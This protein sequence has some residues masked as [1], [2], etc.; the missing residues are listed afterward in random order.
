MYSVFM[1]CF[2]IFLYIF[3]QKYVFYVD[4]KWR[5]TENVS[6]NILPDYWKPQGLQDRHWNIFQ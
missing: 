6:R 3:I 5:F 1:E 2:D 4:K